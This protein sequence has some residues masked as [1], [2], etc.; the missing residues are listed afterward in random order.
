VLSAGESD[1]SPATVRF[2][3]GLIEDGSGARPFEADGNWVLPGIVD[4]HGDAFERS[5]MPRGG[6]FAEI[7]LALADN[8]AQLLGSG[9]TTSYLSATDSWEPGLRSRRALR[10]LIPAIGSRV[11]GPEV[12]LHVRHERCN[13]AEIDELID[14]VRDGTVSML[15]FN[16][17]TPGGIAHIDGLSD[18]QIGRAGIGSDALYALMQ[19][20]VAQ[21]VV[22]L[23]HEVRLAEVAAEGGC[24]TA[25]HDPSVTADLERDLEL[26]VSIA[27]FPMTI[28]LALKYRGRGIDVLLGA[29]NLVRG[30]SHLK[31]LSV[32]D[33]FA[34]GLD[35]ILCSDYHYPSLLQAPFVA[36]DAGL[37]SFGEAWAAVSTRPAIAAGLL[38][39]GTIEPGQRADLVVLRPPTDG[40]PARVIAV[41]V[42]GE[43]AY[44]LR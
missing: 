37:A 32:R 7:A 11:G 34:D 30:G 28:P 33:A 21:R 12:L 29:P 22:G 27:E 1:P 20:A 42:A 6:V 26:G 43:L 13:T 19:S 10:A 3:D 38:N 39:R 31:N 35:P 2:C 17:H 8:D 24:V 18:G 9:I 14:W 16:D 36:A 44:W 40:L 4:A 41:F 15:S 23:E 5:L 25:S